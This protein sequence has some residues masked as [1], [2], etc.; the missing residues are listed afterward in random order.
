MNNDEEEIDYSSVVVPH[1][2]SYLGSS[3][4]LCPLW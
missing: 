3:C 1:I 4:S 2:R